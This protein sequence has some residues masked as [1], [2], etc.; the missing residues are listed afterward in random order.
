MKLSR[1]PLLLL[2]ACA[3]SAQRPSAPDTLPPNFT[4]DDPATLLRQLLDLR[5]RLLKNEFETT[6]AYRA[7]IPDEKQKPILD[8]R[9]FDDVFQLVAHN[10][11]AN[12]DADTQ[13]MSFTLPIQTNFDSEVLHSATVDK[14]TMRDLARVAMYQLSLG[15]DNNPQLFF[16]FAVGLAGAW[17]KQKFMVTAKLDAEEAKRLKTATKAVLYVRFEEPYATRDYSEGGQLMVRINGVQFFDPQTGRVL[18]QTGSAETSAQIKQAQDLA[19]PA[20]DYA[21][22]GKNPTFKRPRI[23]AKPDPLY[24]DEASR[25]KITGDVLL[26]VM[27]SE[28]GQVTQIRTLK[29]LPYGLT[30][31]AIA[32]AIRIKFEPA[33]L[34][35]K[36]VSYPVRVVYSF[37]LH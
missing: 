4:G 7:R 27:L 13:T 16:N 24:T 35:G 1:L 12:Y 18:G 11:K 30:E 5:Q 28:N 21:S 26:E 10:I 23:L 22:Y 34:D 3:V 20:P 25:R 32:A 19:A 29:G 6:A 31:R 2:L 8:T 9:T 33:E 36:K 37:E 15:G 14:K 17:D